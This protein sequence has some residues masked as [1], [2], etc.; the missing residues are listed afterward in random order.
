M[1]WREEQRLS[2]DCHVFRTAEGKGLAPD[3]LD[4]PASLDAADPLDSPDSPDPLDAAAFLDAPAAPASPASL[5]AAAFLDAPAAP[6]SLD[7]LDAPDSLDALGSQSCCFLMCQTFE[8]LRS[9]VVRN[10][11][12]P[13]LSHDWWIPVPPSDPTLSLRNFLLSR[14]L[15]GPLALFTFSE[16]E[17]H[18]SAAGSVKKALS[19]RQNKR[20]IPLSACFH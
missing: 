5:D 8:T 11:D 3:P 2:E 9:K 6:A 20:E 14:L 4:A 19:P 15:V 1:S 12:G 7:S 18:I 13:L 17:I 16:S 10:P